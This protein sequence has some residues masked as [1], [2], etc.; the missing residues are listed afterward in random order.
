MPGPDDEAE[1]LAA[2]ERF[3]DAFARGDFVAME[4][5]WSER[6]TV[7]CL[8]PGWHLLRGRDR[9][10][11]SWRGILRNPTPVRVYDVI[12]ELIGDVGLILCC[13][14][15][16]EATLAASNLFVREGGRWRM[17][18]HHAGLVARRA[19]EESDEDEPDEDEDDDDR[20]LN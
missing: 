1:L 18:H 10:L 11:A 8:H 2:N 19:Q 14:E 3:Y 12:A 20:L 7:L 4:G 13:E 9:V 15:L 6:D 5:L 16:P 17:L